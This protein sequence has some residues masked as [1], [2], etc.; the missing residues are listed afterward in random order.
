MPQTQGITTFYSKSIKGPGLGKLQTSGWPW[1]SG[2][3]GE[4]DEEGKA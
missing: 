1:G 4:H 2:P 3:G